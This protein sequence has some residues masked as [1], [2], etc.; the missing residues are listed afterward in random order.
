MLAVGDPRG[1]VVSANGTPAYA[2]VD[3]FSMT[4]TFHRASDKRRAAAATST[5]AW[6]NSR[7]ILAI[8]W[9]R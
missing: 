5:R 7:G 1:V 9:A 3:R 4:R 2:M 6:I 8:H